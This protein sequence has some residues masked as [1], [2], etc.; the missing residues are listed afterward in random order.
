MMQG[1]CPDDGTTRRVALMSIGGAPSSP[2][3]GGTDPSSARELEIGPFLLQARERILREWEQEV[4]ELPKARTLERPALR[5]H[6]PDLLDQI[7]K[8]ALAG[9]AVLEGPEPVIHASQRLAEGFDLDEVA[10]EYAVL[11]RTILR[12]LDETERLSHGGLELV[13]GA[14]DAAVT[15]A[16]NSYHLSRARTLRAL[17]RIS[18]EALAHT[19]QTAETIPQLMKALLDTT[20]SLDTVALFLGDGDQLELRAAVGIEA[21]VDGVTRCKV[22]E[23]FE[24]RIAAERQPMLLHDAARSPLV[25][26]RGLRTLGIQALYGVP[27]LHGDELIGVAHMGSK[28]ASDFSEDDKQLFRAMSQRAAALIKQQQLADALQESEAR[29]RETFD[30][31]P[32]GIAHVALDGTF[33]RFNRYLPEML[34]YDAEELHRLTFQQITHPDDLEADLAQLRRLKAGE[35]DSYSLEKRYIRKDGRVLWI[36]LGVS[37]L[38]GHRGEAQHYLATIH[39]ITERRVAEQ[40]LRAT[41]E[42]YE[43]ARRAT[44]DVIWDWDL[45]TGQVTWNEQMTALFGYAANEV[46]NHQAWWREHVAPEDRER[47]VAGIDAALEGSGNAWRD[48]YRFLRKDG[49]RAFVVDRGYVARDEAGNAVR[50]VGA[51]QDVTEKKGVEQTLRFLSEASS[52]LADSLVPEETVQRIIQLAVPYLGDWCVV[53]LADDGGPA[54]VRAVQHGDP[55]RA[56][57]LFELLERFPPDPKQAF[58][59]AA[60]MRTGKPELGRDVSDVLLRRAARSPEHLQ[61]LRGLGLVSY[62]FVPLL[63]RGRAF[64]V[65]GL[66]TAESSRRYSSRDLEVATEF[67]RRAALAIDNAR[68]YQESLQAARLREQMLAV[69]SHDLRNPLAAIQTSA[70]L[71]LADQDARGDHTDKG[72]AAV[73]QRAAKRMERLIADLL[74]VASI[75]AGRF[76]VEPAE[77][78]VRALV[79]EAVETLGPVAAEKNITLASALDASSRAVV[80]AD[81]VRLLQ[82]L[83]N[84]IGNALKFCHDRDRITVSAAAHDAVVTFAVRDTGPGIAPHDAEHLFQPYW[85]AKKHARSGTGLGLYISKAIVEAH[86]GRIWVESEP[87]AGSTFR[88]TIPIARKS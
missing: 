62:L 79:S 74:D 43:L 45:R 24:G 64:G 81:R 6:I 29:F 83:G 42:R 61:A 48:E 36:R 15:T 32:T 33:L 3:D 27:L 75:Q 16:V 2:K 63:A 12:L 8:A 86:G 11:R 19:G 28:T 50:M 68:L 66:A 56:R 14:I 23:G 30:R 85:S 25:E 10:T 20:A 46:G 21:E 82:V 7:T 60:V 37:L 44:A 71:L 17:D 59:L 57:A 88:F 39:D 78:D 5:D 34:G 4:R 67:A 55:A 70:S 35:I 76:A 72:P 73:V 38:R 47:V 51:M 49:S 52:T 22:G 53:L 54:R 40:A 31:A 77:E 41:E 58:G 26:S 1:A 84:L 18:A 13:N 87:G 65:I 80:R 9:E 69:V